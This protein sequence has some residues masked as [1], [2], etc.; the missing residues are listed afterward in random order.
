MKINSLVLFVIALIQ[1]CASTYKDSYI[2]FEH[3]WRLDIYNLVYVTSHDI[4]STRYWVRQE[5][6]F[7]EGSP[8]QLACIEIKQLNSPQAF[9]IANINTYGMQEVK[10]CNENFWALD[11][12]ISHKTLYGSTSTPTNETS[13]DTAIIDRNES[14]LIDQ[15]VVKNSQKNINLSSNHNYEVGS[16]VNGGFE[17]SFSDLFVVNETALIPEKIEVLRGIAKELVSFPISRIEIYGVADSSGPYKKNKTLASERANT[18]HE[19]LQEN[20][21]DRVKMSS[22]GTVENKLSSPEE[23]VNQRRFIIR[24]E[25]VKSE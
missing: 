25:L 19:F 14:S 12:Y 13:T 2:A 18:I 1:G 17:L 24:V 16:D 20:G 5:P 21:L 3:D 4:E 22:I 9:Y 10:E 11:N 6:V 23:R 8:H 15:Y 7:P